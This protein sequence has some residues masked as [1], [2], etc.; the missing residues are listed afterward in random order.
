M[1]CKVHGVTKSQTERLSLSFRKADYWPFHMSQ[2][3]THRNK[4]L[5]LPLR[6]RA[7]NVAD[8]SPEAPDLA[9][10]GTIPGIG[11]LRPHGI[12]EGKKEP[13]DTEFG[14]RAWI[15]ILAPA[16]RVV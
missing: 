3:N 9:K 7:H 8:G 14:I 12:R 11:G 16:E 4:P 6:M 10:A 13:Q 5:C 1:D 2:P 15:A